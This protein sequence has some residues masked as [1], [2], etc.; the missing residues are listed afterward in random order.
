M[1]ERACGSVALNP[2]LLE[3]LVPGGHEAALRFT[4]LEMQDYILQ[5]LVETVC[6]VKYPERDATETLMFLEKSRR[7]VS[8]SSF[9]IVFYA[10]SDE[11]HEY[12]KTVPKL[13]K[14]K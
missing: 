6:R 1:S 14:W 5:F 8:R 7:D 9:L 10:L 4:V 3:L 2:Y 11:L 12:L 13:E